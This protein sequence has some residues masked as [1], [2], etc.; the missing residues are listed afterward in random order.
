MMLIESDVASLC[1]DV[2]AAAV[3]QQ[4]VTG[5]SEAPVH[6]ECELTAP[7]AGKS[8]VGETVQWSR[9][10]ALMVPASKLLVW[11]S[12]SIGSAGQAHIEKLRF[13]RLG[14]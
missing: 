1:S 4:N 2:A 14:L 10:S 8:H 5:L 3:S 13:L 7:F 11:F 9:R 6:E 12:I